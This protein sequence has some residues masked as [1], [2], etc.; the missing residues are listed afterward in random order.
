MNLFKEKYLLCRLVT[1]GTPFVS[2]LDPAS[3][4]GVFQ[5]V[6][7]IYNSVFSMFF[8]MTAN[9]DL[10]RFYRSPNMYLDLD[11]PKVASY[12]QSSKQGQRHTTTHESTHHNRIFKYNFEATFG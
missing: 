1:E 5:N 11:L 3:K 4:N 6:A 8:N 2:D 7:F 10:T 12:L 9:S